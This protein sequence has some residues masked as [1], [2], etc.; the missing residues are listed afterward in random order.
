MNRSA[1]LII[2][3]VFISLTAAPVALAV[4]VNPSVAGPAPQ[5]IVLGQ[6]VQG[7]T[8]EAYRF[9][10][11]PIRVALVGGIHGGYEANTAQ[12]VEK[13][14]SYFQANPDQVPA[15]VSLF[16][17]PFAN[18]D[19]LADG[20]RFNSH[21]VD[22]N[23]NWGYDWTPNAVWQNRSVDAGAGPF[24]E[25]ETRALKSFLEN[26]DFQA[27]VFYHSAAGNIVVGSCGA[28]LP[29]AKAIASQLSAATGYPFR[30]QGFDYYPVTGAA[31]DYLTCN[32]VPVVDLELSDHQ[33]IEWNRN[34]HGILALMDWL[35]ART[36]V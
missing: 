36:G 3:L 26:G 13:A 32:N 17:V 5:G 10:S 34:L 14:V 16:L 12:L 22:L 11:G 2:A 7:R 29:E 4:P 31:A 8:I 25:P 1:P 28:K 21:G 18:P 15:A 19:G 6:S 27:A 30:R 9:G 20:G 24:S 33:H 35:A 23:R